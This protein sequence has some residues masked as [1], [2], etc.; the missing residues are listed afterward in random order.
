MTPVL[1]YTWRCWSSARPA[2]K[3]RCIFFRIFTIKELI[4]QLQTFTTSDYLSKNNC[5]NN[6][7][8]KIFRKNGKKLSNYF[9]ISKN[10]FSTFSVFWSE[11]FLRRPLVQ[12]GDNISSKIM[13][14]YRTPYK[15]IPYIPYTFRNQNNVHTVHTSN[16]IK[17]HP[18]KKNTLIFFHKI[19]V[20]RI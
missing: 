10:I 9:E 1:R 4:V 18:T 20:T 19:L 3:H 2:L 12:G 14:T 5:F 17:H 15:K 13:Y 7:S 8:Y 16:V 6:I 11:W